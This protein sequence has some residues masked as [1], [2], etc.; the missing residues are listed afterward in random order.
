MMKTYTYLVDR[1]P[2][3]GIIT[4]CCGGPTYFLGDKSL[5]QEMLNR[6]AE[7]MKKLGAS[8]LIVACPDCYHTIKHHAPYIEL[9]TLFGIIIEHGLPII[10][11]HSAK[12][13]VTVH[14]SCKAR[15]EKGWQ[16]QQ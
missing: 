6:V 12:K 10:R 4:G 7:D 11:H 3:T 16:K 8:E 5:F 2:D 15:W 1:V 13:V 14:D 9:R